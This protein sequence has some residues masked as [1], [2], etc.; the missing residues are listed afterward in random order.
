MAKKK[1][2]QVAAASGSEGQN[3]TL[4]EASPTQTQPSTTASSNS[5]TNEGQKKKPKASRELPSTASS[6]TLNICRNKHWRY[7]SSYHGPWL[8][9]PIEILETIANINYNTPRPR[10]IDPA[11]LFDLLKIRRLVDEAT[12]LAVRAASDIASP[13]LTNVHGGLPG[14]SPMSML[15]M[16]GPGHGM[17]LSHKRKS[18]MREQASQKLSRAYH[19]DEIAC[20]VATMQGA[21]TIE[22]IGAVVLQRNPQD[23][24]AKYV[25]FF[26]E[27]IPS[28]QMAESTSLESLTEIISEKPNESEALRTRAVVRT[29]KEDYEGAAHDLTA[30]LAVCRIHQ[31][32]HRP[33]EETNSKLS[34]TGKRWRQEVVPAEKDQP[35]SLEIQLCFLRA[36]AY[37]SCACQHIEDGLSSP[38]KQNGH[39]ESDQSDGKPSTESN[40]Q[41]PDENSLRKQ[42]EARKLV[43]KYAK[44]ALRDLL[45][46]LSHFE[47]APNLPNLIVKDFNDRV[48]LS[49]QGA[50]NPR[51]SEATYLLE[52]YTTYTLAELFA[53]VPPSDLPPYPNEDV[54]NPDE[55]TQSSDKPKVCEG[56]SYHPLMTDALHS[57]LLCHCL[58]QTSAK[59]LQ[60]HTYMAARLIRLADGYPIFQACRSP[61]RSDWLEVL[62]RADDSWL[63]LSASWD[64]L[65]TPA[66]LPFHYDPLQHGA[67][68][69]NT[70]A[71]RKEAAAA[72]ASLINGGSSTEKP[73]PSPEEL[74]RQRLRERDQRVRVALSD[75]RV[76]DEDTFRASIEAQEKRAE[77]E[78]RAAAAAASQP[79]G[80]S[81]ADGRPRRWVVDDSEFYPVCT[82][83][84]TMIAQWVC[85]A[86]VVA[87]TT[88]RKKRTKRPEGKTDTLADSANKMSLKDTTATIS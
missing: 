87:S 25:H 50:R 68:S 14:S 85:E 76:C 81:N 55:Q 86:P 3:A 12:N 15:G 39:A 34:H 67:T 2:K 20:S 60:R 59:E 9:M 28:R 49:A 46:F 51:P 43:K 13:V 37:L 42:A 35:T 45:A 44:W 52:P 78:D 36:S 88:R 69:A 53:A 6:Q 63:Q 1:S 48:N 64:T 83:R 31:Q 61:A 84:A 27:K 74:R 47:Y 19:L 18:Q 73:A 11:V 56:S 33:N 41:E 10:P 16:I 24:D 4:D 17:K 80:A 65:C 75:Q 30:A 21:S 54:T 26:H 77:Q 72:A 70:G 82:A 29:F 66:P 40:G 23:L 79:N 5:S 8:Q 57:L 38:R 71:S 22:E 7:I 32:P 58:I 62:R